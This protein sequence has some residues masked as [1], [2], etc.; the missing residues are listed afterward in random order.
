MN[1]HSLGISDAYRGNIGIAQ[2]FYADRG[3]GPLGSTTAAS[4][5]LGF[6]YPFK[7]DKISV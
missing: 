6:K 7:V 1:V 3:Q 5:L 2:L 4:S